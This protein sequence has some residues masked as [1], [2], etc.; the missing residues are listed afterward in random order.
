M[1]TTLIV[2]NQMKVLACAHRMHPYNIIVF[3]GKRTGNLGAVF[4]GPFEAVSLGIA[5]AV[6]VGAASVGTVGKASVSA[7][8]EIAAGTLG[9]GGCIELHPNNTLL[10]FH[11]FVL[12]QMHSG[13]GP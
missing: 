12:V 1:C 2:T 13:A 9:G 6:I 8:S 10:I 7:L 4:A 3:W 5:S 11:T